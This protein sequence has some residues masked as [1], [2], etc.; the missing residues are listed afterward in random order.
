MTNISDFILWHHYAKPEINIMSSNILFH[1]NK[2]PQFLLKS[3][4]PMQRRVFW[5]SWT[6]YTFLSRSLPC[7]KVSCTFH[8]LLFPLHLFRETFWQRLCW[9]HP[10]SHQGHTVPWT[11]SFSFTLFWAPSSRKPCLPVD[12][13]PPMADDSLRRG[14][15]WCD[16][17]VMGIC[18]PPTVP[19]LYPQPPPLQMTHPRI[20]RIPS[21][22]QTTPDNSPRRGIVW[23]DRCV[24]GICRMGA[25]RAVMLLT[26]KFV[27]T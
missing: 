20:P 9:L 23:C 27:T 1:N 16:F 6:A 2:N 18:H 4:S 26:T 21:L 7:L 24:M 14:I 13:F 8:G 11:F 3:Y 12:S 17:C 25:F 22:L 15:V 19:S 5:W 10:A